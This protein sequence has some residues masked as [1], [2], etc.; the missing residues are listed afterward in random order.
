[1]RFV[2]IQNLALSLA[3][4]G[5]AGLTA[6]S[7]SPTAYGQT[8]VSGDITGHVADSTGAV[9]VGASVALTSD[10]NGSRRE[11]TSSPEGEFRFSLLPPGTYS[12]KVS[13]PGLVGGASHIAVSVGKVASITIAVAPAAVA[14]DVVVDSSSQPLLQTEDANITTTMDARSIEQLPV[15]GGDISTLAFTAPGVNLSTGAGYGGFVAFGLPATSNLFTM[16]GNDIMDPY[17]NLNNSGASNLSLGANEIADVAIVNNGYDAQYGRYPGTQIN[18]TTKSGSNAFH[19]N[20]QWYWNGRVLN[21]NDWIAKNQ[22]IYNGQPN[23]APFA[24]S[25]QWAA[26]VGGPILK[27][28]LFFFFDTEG[29]RYVLPGGGLTYIPTTG[30]MND[31][32]AN[33]ATANPSEVNYYKTIANLYA[34]ASGAANAAPMPD[35]NCGDLDGTTLNGH[36]Y[37]VGANSCTRTFYSPVNNLNTEALWNIRADQNLGQTDHVSYRVHHDWGM[38]ATGTDPINPVFNS[39]SVQPEW[40]GQLNE[41]HTFNSYIANQFI[42]SGMYYQALFGPPDMAA[43]TKAYPTTLVFND[44]LF[45]ALGGTDYNVN[46]RNVQQYQLVDDVSMQ[47]GRHSLKFGINYRGNKISDYRAGVYKV[48]L[49]SINS[50]TD[51][52]FGTTENGSTVR[53]RFPSI[54]QVAIGAM[55]LGL[56][57]QDEWAV[58]DRLKLTLS[59]RMDHNANFK[60][61]NDC[62]SRLTAAFSEI[63]HDAT[64]PYSKAINT[65][66]SQAFPATDFAVIQPRVGFSYAP[67]GQ[68][69]RFVVRGGVGLFSDLPAGTVVD[70]FITNAPQILDFTYSY[71]TGTPATLDATAASGS[72]YNMVKASATAFQNG[73]QSGQTLTQIQAATTALAK[74]ASFTVPNYFSINDTLHTPKYLEYNLETQ[75]QLSH[76]DVVDFNYVGNHSWNTLMLSGLGNIFSSPGMAGLPLTAPDARFGTVTN[77]G[78]DGSANYNGLTT[79]V[80]HTAKYGL[81]LTGNYTYSHALDLVSNGGLELF[82]YQATYP[83]QQ[84]SPAGPSKL[85][86]GNADYDIR[87]SSSIQY[88]WAIPYKPSNGI[89]KTVGAGWALSGN[90]FYRGGYPLSIINSQINSR[91]LGGKSTSGL[92]ATLVSG[93]DMNCSAKPN[94]ANINAQVCFKGDTFAAVPKSPATYSYGFG[95]I[96]RNSF[97]GPH[98][99]NSDLQVNKETKVAERYTLKIGAN[100]YNVL[101]HANFSVPVNSQTLNTFGAVNSTVTPPSSPYG[102]FE[103]SAVSGRVVQLLTSFSF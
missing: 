16:N 92:L 14:T 36:L 20:A 80:R 42:I 59:L 9:V 35:D 13:S 88:V 30:F 8:I 79:S 44:G 28:K 63:S 96:A 78:N 69:G 54:G 74:G 21:A 87:H 85:N 83:Q 37:D 11:A 61:Y 22:Q 86:H 5:A 72:A 62:I 47:K 31:V 52:A 97:R 3:L 76:S 41:T 1:M 65:G 99:F 67:Y 17:L 91:Q 64:T 18:Y 57:A 34:G 15:P 7:F 10:A 50:M 89:L 6:T 32:I 45:N 84:L 66:L 53:Q 38:Q 77:L 56:Y 68:T 19:G 2:R 51:F 39:N 26:S 4:L 27:N 81:T 25:N 90:V 48:S 95:N 12:I 23:K 43:A 93:N 49:T 98:Y 100:F 101:N 70:N 75:Y 102:S 40:E 24:N 103:G 55:T 94:A 71:A 82:S 33:L 58:N 29:L 60:C 46:G 73:F